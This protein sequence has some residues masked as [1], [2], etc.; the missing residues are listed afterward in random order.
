MAF[1]IRVEKLTDTERDATF[2]FFDPASPDEVGE[3]RLTKATGEIAMTKKTQQ[4]FFV[5]ALRKVSDAHK[6]GELPT[7]LEWAS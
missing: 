6:L 1:Y 2:R 5:R 4:T 3:L 7:L